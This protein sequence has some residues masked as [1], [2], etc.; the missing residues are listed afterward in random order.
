MR[1]EIE[2]EGEEVASLTSLEEGDAGG[3]DER[4][5]LSVVAQLLDV[6]DEQLQKQLQRVQKFAAVENRNRRR[7]QLDSAVLSTR[8]HPT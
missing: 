3:G 2:R 7:S 6:V 4:D 5:E 8:Q 1:E